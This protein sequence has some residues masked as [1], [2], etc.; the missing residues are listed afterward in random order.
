[1]EGSVIF[2]G[3]GGVGKTTCAWALGLALVGKTGRNA[4]APDLAARSVLVLSIDPAHSLGHVAGVELGDEP[5][6]VEPGLWAAEI[7]VE[8]RKQALLRDVADASERTMGH[9]R[10]LNLS[11]LP[12]LLSYT[13]GLEEQVLVEALAEAFKRDQFDYLLVDPPATA[14]ALR[15]LA[16]PRLAQAWLERLVK[17]RRDILQRRGAIARIR[18]HEPAAGDAA[19]T[20]GDAV[21]DILAQQR[22]EMEVVRKWLAAP[23]TAWGL[24]VNPDLLSV[25]ESSR[26]VDAMAQLDKPPSLAIVNRDVSSELAPEIASLVNQGLPLVRAPLLPLAGRETPSPGKDDLAALGGRLQEALRLGANQP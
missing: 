13:P 4:S 7:D 20:K 19:E 24:V 16:L 11:S 5:R 8:G 6:E 9:L 3:K 22:E 26:I 25:K 10:A 14:L 21:S 17:L 2:L 23:T 15:V 18:R 1:V 12:R